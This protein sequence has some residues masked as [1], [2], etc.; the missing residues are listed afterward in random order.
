[1]TAAEHNNQKSQ[2]SRISR[3]ERAAFPRGLTGIGGAEVVGVAG[4]EGL[5]VL[6][7]QVHVIV[8]QRLSTCDPRIPAQI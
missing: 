6:G 1:M 5:V 8:G 2:T 7:R 4:E 3:T